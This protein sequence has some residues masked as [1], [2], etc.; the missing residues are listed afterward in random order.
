M[1]A[2]RKTEQ[3]E[4]TNMCMVYDNNGNV[5]VQNR[6]KKWK[7]LAF[8]GGH[9]EPYESIVDSVIREIKEET[10]LTIKNPQ[11]CGIKQAFLDNGG[12]Y[13]V[14]LYKTNEFEGEL[15]SNDE[16]INVWIPLEELKQRKSEMADNFEYMLEVF[17]RDELSE[18]YHIRL[19]ENTVE[20]IV[21]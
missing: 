2:Q 8:P 14:Y 18:H 3:A 4:F 9:L 6:I 19:D 7:G 21:K 1:K 5:L 10:G 20:D 11:L 17:T 16:G 12:R 15:T 13:I